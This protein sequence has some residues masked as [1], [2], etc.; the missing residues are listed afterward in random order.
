MT[1]HD[2]LL[3]Q[4]G[5]SKTVATFGRAF[6]GGGLAFLRL[7]LRHG[8]G[9]SRECGLGGRHT[10]N[11]RCCAVQAADSHGVAAE[12]E[13]KS[14]APRTGS[15]HGLQVP[16]LPAR[17]LGRHSPYAPELKAAGK[18]P[19]GYGDDEKKRAI[20]MAWN[21]HDVRIRT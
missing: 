1:L 19:D 13:E 5:Q 7:P 4:N 2:S 21:S 3:P 10:V 15:R 9:V 8:R 20:F 12:E 6:F 14:G 17:P 16:S 11:A 18:A